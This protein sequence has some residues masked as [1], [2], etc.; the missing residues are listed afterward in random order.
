VKNGRDERIE[1][2]F[3]KVAPI[4]VRKPVIRASNLA[5]RF[6][7]KAL[8]KRKERS[9]SPAK[10]SLSATLLWRSVMARL[11]IRT[12]FVPSVGPACRPSLPGVPMGRREA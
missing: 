8:S 2:L 6:F 1:V 12:S 10:L 11:S 9:R 5:R 7:L 4:D 3:R